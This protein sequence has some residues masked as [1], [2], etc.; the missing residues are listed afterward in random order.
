[1]IITMNIKIGVTVFFGKS[2]TTETGT[3]AS[4]RLVPMRTGTIIVFIIATMVVGKI[5]PTKI[6]KEP[7]NH[8]CRAPQKPHPLCGC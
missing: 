7:Y 8:P 6:G 5:G 3:T 2:R 4:G 1:M